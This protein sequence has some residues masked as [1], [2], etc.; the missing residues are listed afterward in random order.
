MQTSVESR[1][2]TG[3]DE[4][5]VRGVVMN[6]VV[7][8]LA[9]MLIVSF[10][11]WG[12]G[13]RGVHRD[14]VLESPLTEPWYSPLLATYAHINTSHFM[15]NA[16]H[17]GIVGGLVGLSTSVW[18]FHV[19][20]I[21]TGIASSVVQVVLTDAAGTAAGTIG[22]S[23]AG[24]ALL[25][26]L[27]VSN[28]VSLPAL[29]SMSNRVLILL[30]GVASV[31]LT[32]WLSPEGSALL[33]HLTGLL[34]GVVTGLFRLLKPRAQGPFLNDDSRLS[35]R[36]LLLG[37]G[38]A[39]GGMTALVQI[40]RLDLDS[41][42]FNSGSD[43]TTDSP[44]EVIQQL[45]DL[46]ESGV[47]TGS[48]DSDRLEKLSHKKAPAREGRTFTNLQED[49]AESGAELDA[50]NGSLELG[51]ERVEV[52]DRAPAPEVDEVEEFAAVGWTVSFTVSASGQT[53]I[54]TNSDVYIVAQN[55][56]GEWELW[57]TDQE[58]PV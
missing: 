5:I 33:S 18:R 40:L 22:A 14:F 30:I 13:G 52:V 15:S 57:S 2:T 8:T 31:S 29:K 56:E 50:A 17:I 3:P 12:L 10:L 53:D 37:G 46:L 26:Y 19:F 36:Q 11:G 58:L 20:F 44:E 38:A 4:S 16:V 27:L 21:F 54:D 49:V 23:G 43:S 45:F 39:V 35:R 1:E 6:P 51:V 9:I 42:I 24:F 55:T 28:P 32:V 25:G 48:I 7:Q 41:R 34:L 47:S